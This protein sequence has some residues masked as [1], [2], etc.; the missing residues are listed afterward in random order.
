MFENVSSCADFV[1]F[2]RIRNEM[3]LSKSRRQNY[4]L[5]R[6]IKIDVLQAINEV[7][8]KPGDKKWSNREFA[9]MS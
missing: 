1:V 6:K 9:G 8:P 7:E 2:C 3:S 4:H 5:D